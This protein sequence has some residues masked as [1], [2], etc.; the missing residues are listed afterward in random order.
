MLCSGLGMV[1]GPGLLQHG[2]CFFY[3][4]GPPLPLILIHGP[5]GEKR[6]DSNNVKRHAE[7]PEFSSVLVRF[8]AEMETGDAAR[9]PRRAVF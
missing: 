5:R 6:R 8:D 2:G 4:H 3:R 9:R 7:H 1:I